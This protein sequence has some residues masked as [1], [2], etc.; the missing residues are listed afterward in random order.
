MIED[1]DDVKRCVYEESIPY[2]ED[3]EDAQVRVLKE[4]CKKHDGEFF[5]VLESRCVVKE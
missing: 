5:A 3:W 4:Y 2:G 1:T